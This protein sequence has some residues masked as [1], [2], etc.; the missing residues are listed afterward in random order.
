MCDNKTKQNNKKL[1]CCDH[2]NVRLPDKV[3]DSVEVNLLENGVSVVGSVFVMAYR[4]AFIT[5][6]QL[7]TEKGQ[8]TQITMKSKS[9]FI[10]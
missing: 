2:S 6:L 3:A 1:K 10:T 9:I 7:K 4:V 5:L 8:F